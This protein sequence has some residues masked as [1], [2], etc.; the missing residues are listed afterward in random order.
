MELLLDPAPLPAGFTE[1]LKRAGSVSD[2]KARRETR[3]RRPSRWCA[4]QQ[5]RRSADRMA[6]ARL[7]AAGQAV[8]I[9]GRCRSVE[10]A[11]AARPGG[12]RQQ[13][14]CHAG[15]CAGSQ[16]RRR[17]PVSRGRVGGHHS[18]AP[19]G[20]RRRPGEDRLRCGA[21]SHAAAVARSPGTHRGAA[22][23]T[24]HP[25]AVDRSA[26][27]VFGPCRIRSGGSP[28]PAFAQGV[29]G[30]SALHGAMAAAPGR[31]WT[32]ADAGT[33]AIRTDGG[34]RSERPR[35][36]RAGAAPQQPGRIAKQSHLSAGESG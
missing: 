13:Q 4:L 12:P 28:R 31:A 26:D 6:L 7:A 36:V 23:R 32:A 19:Q 18:A 10:I 24:R 34:A 22:A 14:R 25:L 15:R 5:R 9:G 29:G 2:G 8:R 21:G 1:W 16:R 3:R 17:H 33:G 35:P 20:G 27:G 11:A 30:A